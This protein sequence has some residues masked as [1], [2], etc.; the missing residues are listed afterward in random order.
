MDGPIRRDHIFFTSSFHWLAHNYGTPEELTVPTA[1]ERKGDFGSSL[2]AGSNGQPTPVNL[3]NPFSV[4][5]SM[6]KPLPACGVPEEHQ[7]HLNPISEP[8]A[9]AAAI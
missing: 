2:V 3:F 8:A 7:L 5:Q 4:T 6:L 1:L 9:M